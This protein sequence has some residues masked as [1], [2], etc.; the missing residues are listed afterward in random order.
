[1]ILGEMWCFLVKCGI[2]KVRLSG[3]STVGSAQRLGR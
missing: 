3:C 2:I 1:M